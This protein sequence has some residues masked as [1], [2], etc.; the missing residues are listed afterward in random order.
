[1]NKNFKL[2]LIT[3]VLSLPF[4]W[5]ANLL[6]ADLKN[7]FYQR[8][9]THNPQ[10]LAAQ[11]NQLAFEQRIESLK[12]LR[13]KEMAD[14]SMVARSAISLL[15]NEQGEAK[16]LFK[17]DVDKPLPI[18]S[19]TKLM[20]AYVVLANYDLA[21]EIKISQEA[22]GQEENFGKLDVG[23]F[24]S[25]ETLLYPLL[26]ES[27]NDAAFALANDYDGMTEQVFVELMNLEAQ[28]MGLENTYFVN[29]TG[30]DLDNSTKTNYSSARD[31]TIFTQKL[32]AT[33][34]IWQILAIPQINL[35]GSELVNS[36]Q[37]LTRMP[38]IIGGKTGYTEEALGCFLLVLE[39]PKNNQYLI[40]VILGT[41]NGR[42][43]EMEKL[44]NWLNQAYN[45]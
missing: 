27:S 33:P 24:L 42:F 25:V 1:M 11:A 29:V 17:Q 18:A 10:I 28:K 26:I 39:A 13:N 2:F 43:H 8:E 7:F 34:L 41:N 3:L 31:L 32:L 40:N 19:L 20:T 35:Y 5:G 14:L 9:F 16:T 22:V 6:E 4:W 37:L 12:P 36:N 23:S 15:V 30:L 38:E 44:I 45:W 21:K